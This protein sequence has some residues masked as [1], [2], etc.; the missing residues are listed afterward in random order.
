MKSHESDVS[1]PNLITRLDSHRH[2]SSK[3]KHLEMTLMRVTGCGMPGFSERKK[4]EVGECL[5]GSV[6]PVVSVKVKS[7]E[8]ELM[9]FQFRTCDFVLWYCESG[10]TTTPRTS[11]PRPPLRSILF[12]TAM[13][14]NRPLSITSFV[15]LMIRDP[16]PPWSYGLIY[17]V[18]KRSLLPRLPPST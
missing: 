14:I 10:A 16:H 1:F 7:F 6:T 9:F 15:A 3:K 18:G 17:R 12:I 8:L 11:P 2:Q 4:N 13:T 5:S